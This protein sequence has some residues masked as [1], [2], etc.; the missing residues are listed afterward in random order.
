MTKEINLLGA[1]HPASRA[2]ELGLWNRVVD[3]DRLQAEVDALVQVLLSKNQQAVRQLK[4]IIDK[5]VEADLH[6]AQ[7]FEALSAGLTGAVNGMWQIEDADQAAG[8]LSFVTGGEQW[9]TRR[10][11]ARSFWTDGPI[12]AR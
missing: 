5:G 10:D 6:T 9:R 7:A 11:A 4:F 3:D 1:L 2:A 12:A 8:I